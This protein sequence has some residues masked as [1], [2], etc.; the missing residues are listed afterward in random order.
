MELAAE[1]G[2]TT[3]RCY[4][5]L[6]VMEPTDFRHREDGAGFRTIHRERQ[7]R[8]PPVIIGKVAGQD[9]RQTTTLESNMSVQGYGRTLYAT[10]T[11][12]RIRSAV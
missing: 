10:A 9:A 8:P 2:Y 5:L 12:R 3:L 1:F 7:M 4:P 6:M 11:R